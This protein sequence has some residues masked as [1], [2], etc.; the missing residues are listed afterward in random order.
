MH[1]KFYKAVLVVMSLFLVLSPRLFSGAA[2]AQ[3]TRYLIWVFD[4]SLRDSQFGYYDGAAVQATE[5]IYPGADIEGLA[6]LN[7]VIYASG[8]QDGR[9][10][11]TL[12]TLVIDID[13]NTAT[14][15][16][17]ADILNADGSPFFEVVALSARSDGTLWGY[18][19]RGS[20]RGI[21]QLDAAT[22]V[23]ELVAPFDR[24]VEAISWTNG[25]LWLA[26]DNHF[27]RWTPGGEITPAFDLPGVDQIEA[28][29]Q[30]NGLLY[31]GVHNDDR[32]VIAIDPNAGVILPDGGFPAPDDI[33]GLTFCPLQPG[34]EETPTPPETPVATDTPTA[35]APPE[36]P[37]A[38]DTPTAIAPPE[39]PVAT[40]TPT[41]VAPP[42]TP[43]ATDT[44]TAVAP[45]ETPTVTETPPGGQ[46]TPATPTPPTP[47]PAVTSTGTPPVA[48][49]IAPPTNLEET[50][51]PGAPN[52]TSLYLP[53]IV[54]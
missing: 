10:P 15:T 12:N 44:P 52:A 6:C 49:T 46:A 9:A 3:E 5:P 30:I 48:P 41:A 17:F 11:S 18:A 21:I 40:D 8:G 1:V 36:T 22:G 4:R 45:P 13:T 47:T 19:D 43:V 16:K 39:T 2:V 35:V 23:A 14:L 28:L 50:A 26:G 42:E 24:K 25:V 7:N 53:L 27:Y 51:E 34:P 29:E 37:V 33:E 54:R 32:G 31:A 20:Q 38:T